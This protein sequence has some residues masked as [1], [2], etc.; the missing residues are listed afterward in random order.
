M[1]K[2]GGVTKTR[3][4]LRVFV[5][6]LS[7]ALGAVGLAGQNLTS[8]GTQ[9]P[10]TPWG[11]PDLQ[12]IWQSNAMDVDFVPFQ[13]PTEFGERRFL[14]DAEYAKSGRVEVNTDRQTVIRERNTL[15][16]VFFDP[17]SEPPSRRSSMIVDPPNGR[18]PP[19]TA[20]AQQKDAARAAA[21]SQRGPADTWEDISLWSRCITRTLPGAWV[22]RRYNNFRHI[23]QA[24]GYVM[25]FFEE[26][27]DARIIPLDGR[28]H[29]GSAIR[30]WMGDSRGRWEGNTLVIETTNFRDKIN[31]EGTPQEPDD[32]LV[33]THARL[34]ERLTRI[35]GTTIDFEFT[36][37]DPDTYTRPVTLN[38]TLKLDTTHDQIIEYSCHEGST[39]T[40]L[41]L[42][43][44]RAEEKAAAE[45]A[46]SQRR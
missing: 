24:P 42:S 7:V 23:L 33:G 37:D 46:A 19:L 14:T 25:I 21:R 16:S 3:R 26:I 31:L 40:L 43:G 36:F 22:P 44:G 5:L 28:P 32:R 4:L 13:R 8:T 29:V 15:S 2:G 34:I 17:L 6:A 20:A 39:H 45:A 27:H 41:K 18:L 35:D 1:R 38:L 11:D 9:I 12:G 10:R 30:G